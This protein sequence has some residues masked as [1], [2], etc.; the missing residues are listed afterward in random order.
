M[1]KQTVLGIVLG[2]VL[3]A[4][5][6]IGSFYLLES[7]KDK[8]AASNKKP[9]VDV[10]LQSS[11]ATANTAPNTQSSSALQVKGESTTGQPQSSQF[12][13][14]DKFNTYEQFSDSKSTQFQDIEIGKGKEAAKGDTVAVAYKG[15][16][17]NGTLFDESEINEQNQIEAISLTLGSGQVIQGWE[18]GILGMKEGGK[19]RL[20]IPS[21]LGYGEASQGQIPPNSMLIFDVQLAQVQKAQTAPGL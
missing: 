7:Q 5:L 12:P 1:Q 6:S 18:Q 13:T 21:Q 19:R 8:S 3:L 15:Y 20:I 11:K 4:G 17:T 16:L 2:T 10:S 9:A 14:P